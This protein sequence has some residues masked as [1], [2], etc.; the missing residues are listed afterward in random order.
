MSRIRLVKI[1]VVFLFVAFGALT[2]LTDD[3][4]SRRA[5]AK[6]T[7]PDPGHTGAP[8]EKTCDECHVPDSLSV[9]PGQLLIGAPQ[10]YVPGQTYQLTLNETNSDPTRQRWG[11]Q[12]TALDD[13]GDRAGMLQASAD[14]RTQVLTGGFALNATRQYVEHTQAGTSVGQS[15]G[16][17][18]SFDWT[19]P[20]TDVGPV[21]FYAAGNQA[22]N[23]SNS[24]GDSISTIFVVVT[25]STGAAN[26]S[27]TVSPSSQIVLPG[28]SSTVNVTI[29]PSN[30]F[31]GTVNL[32]TANLPAGEG[33]TFSPAAVNITDASPRTSTLT[34]T[35]NT[36]TPLGSFNVTV[37][38]A[39]GAL[40]HGA[41]LNLVTGP[42]MTD[43]GLAVR[44]LASGLNQPTAL[45][46]LGAGDLL[47]LEKA[48]G[49]V[50]RV[51]NGVVQATPVLD[52][53]VN[54]FSERGLLGI[55][56]HPHFPANPR[57]YLY[58]TESSTGAD[59]ENPDEV[60]LRGNRVDSFLWNGSTLAFE[61]NLIKLHAF[62]QDA[63]QPPRGNHNGG[64]IRFGPDGK[65]Y[66][67]IGDNGR[68]GNLQNLRYGPSAT[69][70]GPAVADDQFG[71]PAPDKNHLTGVILRLNDDGT[72]PSDNPFVGIDPD[73]TTKT[74]APAKPGSVLHELAGKAAGNVQKVFAYGIRNSFGMAFDPASG[75]LWTQENGDDS[76]DEINRVEAGFDGGWI[77]LMGPSSRVA[78]FKQIEV[79]RGDSLQQNR[80]LPDQ[81]ADTPAEALARLYALPGSHYT[82]PEFSWKYA[83]A[84]S[85]IGFVRG[86][87]LGA[88]FAGDLLVGASRTTLAGGYLFRFKLTPDRRHLSFSDARLNDTVADN[89]DKFD[90]TESESLLIGRDFGITTDIETAPNGNVL[91]LSLSNGAIYELSAAPGA[92]QPAPVSSKDFGARDSELRLRLSDLLRPAS[93]KDAACCGHDSRRLPLWW[94]N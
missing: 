39:S 40:S 20:A 26:F 10:S 79:S 63:G 51:T 38:G 35:T 83:V 48:T 5:Y 91:V 94:D 32:S 34:L 80:W 56:L 8:G 23:D 84:P 47:V 66:V 55:A 6:S 57:V 7:G 59:T 18:W 11:F 1:I 58:W 70:V 65:L 76:F 12:L 9:A 85:P 17:T 74:A 13:N 15:G 54:S 60:P 41:S 24:S 29:T 87:G 27:I 49:K 81:I 21:T 2:L 69:P 73:S 52:L 45:A 33:A 30:G 93:R 3:F 82:E 88:T 78:E 53:A 4:G 16:A 89:P 31:T 36:T 25:P 14:G 77:Q 75:Y 90:L 46:F 22:N 42:T 37:A 43:A 71:G 19:A 28:A 67:I 86:A 72:T 68:R 50:L 44:Q 64:V 92:S 61:K 62:Q